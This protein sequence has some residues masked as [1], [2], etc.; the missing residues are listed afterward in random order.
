MPP[1]VLPLIRSRATDTS[2]VWPHPLRVGIPA[3]GGRSRDEGSGEHE[4]KWCRDNM[5]IIITYNMFWYALNRKKNDW[6]W[7][8]AGLESV[9]VWSSHVCPHNHFSQ[10]HKILHLFSEGV[11]MDFPDHLSCVNSAVKY[12]HTLPPVQTGHGNQHAHFT[13]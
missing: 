11:H 5:H 4:D 8:R 10:H 12:G 13:V 2:T 7:V 1:D 6:G 9:L 3:P